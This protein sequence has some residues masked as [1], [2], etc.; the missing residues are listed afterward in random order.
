M[1]ND[2]QIESSCFGKGWDGLTEEFCK[3][4]KAQVGCKDKFVNGEF[5]DYLSKSENAQKT[6]GDISKELSISPPSIQELINAVQ[7][8][9]G[10]TE[11]K[12]EGAKEIEVKEAT[13]KEPEKVEE[14][15]PVEKPVVE[16]KQG[17][18]K[19]RR[20]RRPSDLITCPVCGGT[21]GTADNL[22]EVC[23]GY[24]DISEKKWNAMNKGNDKAKNPVEKK[25]E[26]PKVKEESKVENKKSAAIANTKSTVVYVKND[27]GDTVA[28]WSK[29]PFSITDINDIA[30]HNVFEGFSIVKSDKPDDVIV[31]FSYR[32]PSDTLFSK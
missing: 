21:G 16:A 31:T 32:M 3:E 28:T 30:K 19:A 25:V 1:G 22:C 27:S 18:V 2:P 5:W 26:T 10:E 9:K 13:V 23:G 17:P 8:I 6:V 14:E 4:C 24:G 11:T 12:P 20:G 29:L 15:K 7:A